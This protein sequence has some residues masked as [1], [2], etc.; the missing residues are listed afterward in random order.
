MKKSFYIFIG[1]VFILFVLFS[2]INT[3]VLAESLNNVVVDISKTKIAP[4][5]E[6]TLT[7]NFGAKLGAYTV[8]V[9][10]DNKIFDYVRS[11]GGTD[12]DDGSKV[13]LVFYDTQG[14]KNPRETASITFKAKESLT[15]SNPTDFSV[16]LTG[17]ATPDAQSYDDILTPFKKDILVEPKYEKY[18]LSLQYEKNILPNQEKDMKLITSSTM[19]KNYDHVR[20]IAKLTSKPSE[21]ATAK[22]LTT[23]NEKVEIDLFQSGWGEAEGYKIGGKNV[24]Q[25]L[26]LRGLFSEE[27]NYS[28]NIKLVDRDNSDTVIAEKNFDL[29]VGEKKESDTTKQETGK[30]DS[31]K[32]KDKEIV[33]DEDDNLPETLPKTGTVKYIAIVAIIGMLIAIYIFITKKDEKK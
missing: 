9:D 21:N 11:E 12:N 30:T 1:I 26:A 22:L 33:K 6:V 23:N 32:T 15:T 17:M 8:D 10:Y 19:G 29:A 5:D 4:G 14:G 3:K 20:L 28:I 2:S 31:N 16:T 27:G 13:R 18:N 7:I 25:E 24:K